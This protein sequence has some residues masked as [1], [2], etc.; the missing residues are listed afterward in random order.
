MVETCLQLNPDARPTVDELLKS[1]WIDGNASSAVL[2]SVHSNLKQFNARRKLKAAVQALVIEKRMSRAV[3]GLNT[4]SLLRNTIRDNSIS[5]ASVEEMAKAFVLAGVESEVDKKQ[6]NAIFCATICSNPKL[7]D[8]I[9]E[10]Y[11][12]FRESSAVMYQEFCQSLVALVPSEIAEKKEFAFRLYDT[13]SSGRIDAPEF[14][15]LVRNLLVGNQAHSAK[16]FERTMA[17]LFREA[18]SDSDGYINLEEWMKATSEMTI[19]DRY[20][21]SVNNLHDATDLIAVTKAGVRTINNRLAKATPA[22]AAVEE[23]GCC[24]VM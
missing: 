13:D 12:V 3:A 15:N 16:F 1:E 11:L 8:Q 2:S 21:R 5:I 7:A 23:G 6:F 19:L 20:F 17:E 9:F 24:V 22:V 10:A 14:E 18:D 4:E